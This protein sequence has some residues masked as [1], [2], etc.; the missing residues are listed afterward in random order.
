MSV[1]IVAIEQLLYAYCHRVDRGTP[2]A[3][4]A[5]FATD[6][7]LRP[8]YDGRYEVRGRAA[9]ESW[10][11]WY[12]THFKSK[13]RHLKHM[14]MSPMIEV[15]GERATGSVYLLASGV[16]VG[17]GEAF[18][19]TGSYTDEYVRNDHR[20]LFLSRRIDVEMMPTP[21]PAV[22]RMAPLGFPHGVPV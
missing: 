7:V 13:V 12:E 17:N 1:D 5:L 8:F 3:V 4:A 16:N 2:A 11:A 18:L 19:A 15:A 6:A 9:V 20:W 22:E 14:I 21:S 10:Y